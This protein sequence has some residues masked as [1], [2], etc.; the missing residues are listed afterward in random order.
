MTRQQR[1][2][3][4][5]YLRVAR[6]R[7]ETEPRSA[8]EKNYATWCMKMPSLIRQ[9][10][11]VQSLHFLNRKQSGSDQTM[12]AQYLTDLA[13]VVG[14]VRAGVGT[15]EQLLAQSRATGLSEY[16]ALTADCTAVAIWFRR[17]AQ[18]ELKG[19]EV[20]ADGSEAQ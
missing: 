8:K 4:E 18:S 7:N 20:Q 2:A 14:T 1:L 15:C 3:H 17:F 5:A 10:G 11:L 9:S 19:D 13:E 12:A 16:L 6:V